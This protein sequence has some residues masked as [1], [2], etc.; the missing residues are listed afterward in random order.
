MQRSPRISE[1]RRAR[2]RLQSSEGVLGHALRHSRDLWRSKAEQ[3]GIVY[4]ALT[5]ATPLRSA[6]PAGRTSTRELGCMV[7]SCYEAGARDPG[8]ALALLCATKYIAFATT[9]RVDRKV[10]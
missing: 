7:V 2:G 9:R 1:T 10:L 8:P 5:A 3:S 4:L 6:W